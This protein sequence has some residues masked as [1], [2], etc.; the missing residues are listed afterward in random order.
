MIY[1]EEKGDLFEILLTL[2]DGMNGGE[3]MYRME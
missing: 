3:W 2:T 1:R